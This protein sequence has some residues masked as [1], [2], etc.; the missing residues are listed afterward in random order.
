MSSLRTRILVLLVLPAIAVSAGFLGYLTLLAAEQ[1]EKLGEQT[2]ARNTLLLVKEK[3]DS[4][5]QFIIEA[6]N[7]AFSSIR[8]EKDETGLQSWRQIADEET[9]SVRAIF[10]L[11]LKGTIVTDSVRGSKED[12]YRLRYLL[13]SHVLTDISPA[14]LPFGQ[15]K[16]VHTF[17]AKRSYLFSFKHVRR[18]GRT[19]I[20][21][22]QHDT[23]YIVREVLPELFTTEEAQTR[24]NVVDSNGRRV[25]GASLSDAG[26]YLVGY[27]FPT[28]LYRWRLQL[29]PQN[30]GLLDKSASNTRRTQTALT[31]AAFTTIMLGLLFVLYGA[32]REWR[33]NNLRSEFIANVSHELKTPLSVI[34]MFS[35]MLLQGVAKS[36]EKREQYVGMI[37]RESERLSTLIENVLDF[38]ALERGLQRYN[39]EKDSIVSAVE[40]AIDTYNNRS[41]ETSIAL[42][43]APGL[44]SV[45]LDRQAVILAT[46]NLLENAEKHGGPDGI[47]VTLQKVRDFVQLRVRDA[48][49]GIP[50][51]ALKKIFV[52]Y[53]RANKPGVRGSGIGLTI[54]K[55]IAEAH[56]GTAWAKNHPDGGA[57]VTMTFPFAGA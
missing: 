24:V 44:P 34:R 4:L 3:V 11:D 29:A 16:Y 45:N 47:R 23:G 56:G 43:L 55:Q 14:E 32:Y 22:S 17:F 27:R 57:E 39:F 53:F 25:Y 33:T 38:A 15:L 19:F 42:E 54:V 10:L 31:L 5:E 35:E 41:D 9:P 21:C 48:G 40:Q 18:Q 49:P 52:R 28:T 51:E 50:E 2:I 8:H 36:P 46:I 37:H 20:L 1:F 30:A 13:R 7:T 26:D 12:R 6:D